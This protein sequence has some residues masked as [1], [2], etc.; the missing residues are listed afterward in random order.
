ML[1]GITGY[2]IA[3]VPVI[4]MQDE[5]DYEFSFPLYP[6]QRSVFI[7]YDLDL[8]TPNIFTT[9]IFIFSQTFP[10]CPNGGFLTYTDLYYDSPLSCQACHPT[11]L[12]CTSTNYS[13]SLTDDTCCLSCS[14]YKYF[15]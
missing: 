8:T 3:G 7:F 1:V 2:K 10:G 14:S 5:V 9:S 13:L 6:D 4:D 12:T 15:E 11:C